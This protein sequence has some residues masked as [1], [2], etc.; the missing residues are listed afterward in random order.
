MTVKDNVAGV[1]VEGTTADTNTKDITAH[2]TVDDDEG[3][4][5][6]RASCGLVDCC[7]VSVQHP[8]HTPCPCQLLIYCMS[9]CQRQDHHSQGHCCQAHVTVEDAVADVIMNNTPSHNIMD[10]SSSLV[11]KDTCYNQR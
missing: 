10:M 7:R 11:A 2:A 3:A 9:P 1:T 8:P 6:G 4:C 5:G